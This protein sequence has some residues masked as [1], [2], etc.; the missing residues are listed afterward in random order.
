MQPVFDQIG[1]AAA[2]GTAVDTLY[3]SVLAD[4]KVS[5]YYAHTDMDRLKAHCPDPRK[6]SQCQ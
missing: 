2:I 5:G 3:V 1:G 6:V 4:P